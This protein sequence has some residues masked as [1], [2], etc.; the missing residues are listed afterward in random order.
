M[1]YRLSNME[2][3][4]YISETRQ[5]AIFLRKKNPNMTLKEIGDIC[6][7]TKQRI[8]YIF[9]V[10]KIPRRRKN[11]VLTRCKNCGLICQKGLK[12][13]NDYC[14]NDFI[15]VSFACGYCAKLNQTRRTIMLYKIRK[16]KQYNFFCS[17][18][19]YGNRRSKKT[20]IKNV[21]K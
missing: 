19:C 12:F 4:H 6:G 15:Y 17:R 21:P 7:V 10:E 3:K 2:P 13:C 1:E 5:K 20:L 9:K 8:Y 16:I 18:K 11:I 14:R